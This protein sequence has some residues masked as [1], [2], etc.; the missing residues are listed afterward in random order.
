MYCRIPS[1]RHRLGRTPSSSTFHDL[2]AVQTRP[3]T[4]ILEGC[5]CAQVPSPLSG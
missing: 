4:I 2:R 3:I 1:L 5:C